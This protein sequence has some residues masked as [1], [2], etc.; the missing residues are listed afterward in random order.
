M[1]DKNKYCTLHK[2]YKSWLQF[3]SRLWVNVDLV[4]VSSHL[5]PSLKVRVIHGNGQNTRGL[6][7]TY[8]VCKRFSHI[9]CSKQVMWSRQKQWGKKHAHLHRKR[10]W[11]IGRITPSTTIKKYS[12]IQFP[13]LLLNKLI[14]VLPLIHT[15]WHWLQI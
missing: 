7:E 15:L 1:T 6:V 3:F 10:K 9:Y 4:Y 2:A 5:R 14:W 8:K 13:F 12:V 11:I